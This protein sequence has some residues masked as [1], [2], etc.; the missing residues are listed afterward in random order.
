ME[1]TAAA[2]GRDPR[3]VALAALGVDASPVEQMSCAPALVK[4]SLA[5]VISSEFS[6]WTEMRM[7]PALILPS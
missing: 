6:V 2:A 7:L 5:R 4:I 1:R 3:S